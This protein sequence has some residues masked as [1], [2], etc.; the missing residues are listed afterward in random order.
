[1]SFNNSVSSGL[2]IDGAATQDRGFHCYFIASDGVAAR[3]FVRT[4]A[5][6]LMLNGFIWGNV[7][8]AGLVV[9][10]TLFDVAA[11]GDASRL[12][13]EADAVLSGN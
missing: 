10:R 11:S 13:Y 7:T 12:W 8:S 3:D 9:Y 4:L 1:M 6:R 5:D 2:I